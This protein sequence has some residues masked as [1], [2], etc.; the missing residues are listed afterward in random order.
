MPLRIGIIGAGAN[1]K[2]R[3]IPGLRACED[4][5]VVSVVNR[6]R[7]SSE[8]AARDLGIPKVAS[9]PE[10]LIA[11]PEIDAVCIGTWPY[12]H[13]EYSI[14]ALEAG[15]HVLCEA[16][17]AS[18]A[19]EAEDMLRAHEAYPHLVAQLVPAPFDFRLGPT[20]TR[21]IRDGAIGTVLEATVTVL[22]GGA[23]DPATPIHWRQQMRYSGRNIMMLGIYNEIVQRWLGDT[24]RV[25]ADG[26]IVVPER[27]DGAGGTA[28]VD[29]PDSFGVLATLA[30]GARTTYT[31]SAV[32]NGAP[33]NGI[34]IFGS[35]GTIRWSA[36][37]TA[38]MAAHGQPFAAIEPDLGTD[39]GWQVESNF[40]RS[41]RTGAPVRL[42]SFED[43]LKYMRFT[44]AAWRSWQSGMAVEI[45]PV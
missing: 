2:L 19:D 21:L 1:T 29:V 22:N 7:E 35:K 24:T 36:D 41:I 45:E 34:T 25:V 8:A 26:R 39:R 30:N 37:D 23:L 32:A 18:D 17:M 43:G 9:T 13:R 4:V 5:E 12:M 10:D 44:D 15:K 3:H 16:R 14:R 27:P 20:I 6:T 33:H 40:V 42:T 38:T 28:T 11:D 31:F